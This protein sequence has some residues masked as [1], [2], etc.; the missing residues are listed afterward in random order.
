MGKLKLKERFGGAALIT[1]A[2]GGLGETFARQIAADGM[3]VVLVA[4]RKDKLETLAAELRDGYGVRVEVIGQDLTA[5][6][7]AP[8]IKE[9][10][11]AKG[12]EIGLLVN[13][14]GYGSHGRIDAL[15]KDTEIRMV[16]L[17]CRTPVA[18]TCE[19]VP[20][21]VAKKKGGL[22]FLASIGAYQPTPFFATYG[23]TKAFNL[24]FGEA[25]WA[26]LKPQ[27]I[28]VIAL[29]PGYTRTNF[30]ENASVTSKPL[31]G[32]SKPEDVVG[33]C[34]RKLGRKPSTIPGFRNWF[35]AWSIRFTPRR[36]AANLAYS[37]SKPAH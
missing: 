25:L 5:A 3:D 19:F 8:R 24:L 20:D 33:R 18:L 2:S 21:M 29:S 4:R 12:L 10:V 22:I 31:G 35:L 28:D 6:D 9:A 7:C 11:K 17:N 37:L 23:A 1:G 16:D 14:A 32:W 26:E 15:D 27:G 36:M 13:N 34:L 30:Q